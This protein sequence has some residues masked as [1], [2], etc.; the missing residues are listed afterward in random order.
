MAFRDLDLRGHTV[1]AIGWG[2][3]SGVSWNFSGLIPGAHGRDG[4]V[5]RGIEDGNPN[6]LKIY[7][8]GEYA[9]KNSRGACLSIVNV[10]AIGCPGGGIY[11]GEDGELL[12]DLGYVTTNGADSMFHS[13]GNRSSIAAGSGLPGTRMMVTT[14]EG[15]KAR[16]IFCAENGSLGY[17]NGLWVMDNAEWELGFA[18]TGALGG[19]IDVGVSFD[20]GGPVI[21]ASPKGSVSNLGNIFTNG[22]FHLPGNS[23]VTISNGGILT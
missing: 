16:S 13:V 7:S 1:N 23:P 12:I 10:S 18:A 14:N 20:Y 21:G 22:R 8:G 15:K 19:K 2:V 17:I 3:Y 6:S 4:F 5:I 11:V 9:I